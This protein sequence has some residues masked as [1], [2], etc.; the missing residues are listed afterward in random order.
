M[1]NFERLLLFLCYL[2]LTT[3]SV[4]SANNFLLLSQQSALRADENVCWAF[5]IGIPQEKI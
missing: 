4:W 5:E 1:C 2:K 3:S